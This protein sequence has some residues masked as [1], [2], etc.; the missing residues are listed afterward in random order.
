[1][2]NLAFNLESLIEMM[3]PYDCHF[4][5]DFVRLLKEFPELETSLILLLESN[6]EWAKKATTGDVRFIVN[7]S[8]RKNPLSLQIKPY[9][10]LNFIKGIPVVSLNV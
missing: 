9:V 2:D 6:T 8:R 4:K 10:V 7:D 1:M 3:K 5:D